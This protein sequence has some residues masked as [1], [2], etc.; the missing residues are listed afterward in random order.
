MVDVD[1]L[2]DAELRTKLAEFGFGVMPIT[3][4]TRKVMVRKLKLL[5]DNQKKA[6][7]GDGRRYTFKLLFNS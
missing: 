6:N 2:T 5:L 3:E 4:T 7:S 1:R